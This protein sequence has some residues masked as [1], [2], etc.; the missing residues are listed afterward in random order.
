MRGLPPQDKIQK[1]YYVY[2]IIK[3]FEVE[4]GKAAPAFGQFGQGVQYHLPKALEKLLEE[5]YLRRVKHE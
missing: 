3:P 5:G 1:P 2:E 4:A